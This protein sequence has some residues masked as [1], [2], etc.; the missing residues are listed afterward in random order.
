MLRFL[1]RLFG[2]SSL[3]ALVFVAAPHSWMA[4]IHAG[5]GMGPL[6][7]SPVVWYLARSTSA[8]YAILGGLFWLVSFDPPR[9]RSVLIYLG[10]ALTLLGLTL[11]VIDVCEGLPLFWTLWEGPIVTL[12]GV[13]IL[14]SSRRLSV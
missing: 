7:D 9:Y 3:F 14:V 6:P 4:T 11:F 5:L 1:L 2:T 10:S 8:F 13:A 12:F